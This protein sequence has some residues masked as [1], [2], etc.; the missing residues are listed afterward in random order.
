MKTLNKGDWV[1][2]DRRIGD[3]VRV[4]Q[5]GIVTDQHYDDFGRTFWDVKFF[6]RTGN[7]TVTISD[8]STLV[9]GP[10]CA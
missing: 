8:P 2:T 5:V 6:C 10:L 7:L 1:V 3:S 4:G 9:K